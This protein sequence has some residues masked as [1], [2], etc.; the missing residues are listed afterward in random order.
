MNPNFLLGLIVESFLKVG[1]RRDSR[2]ALKVADFFDLRF[3][4]S[5]YSMLS[6]SKSSS[7]GSILFCCNIWLIGRSVDLG[8]IMGELGSFIDVEDM[9]KSVV[10]IGVRLKGFLRRRVPTSVA[11]MGFDAGIGVTG[12]EGFSASLVKVGCS[13]VFL[14]NEN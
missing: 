13:V 1:I 5:W 8:G 10:L 4:L 7:E 9:V 14:D 3:S 11:A 6:P 12:I 2:F